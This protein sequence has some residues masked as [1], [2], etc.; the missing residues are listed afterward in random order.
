MNEQEKITL[1]VFFDGITAHIDE[2]LRYMQ[3]EN[4]EDISTKHVERFL[5]DVKYEVEETRKDIK[6]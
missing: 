2:F 3:E 1:K 5:N 6:I 4:K